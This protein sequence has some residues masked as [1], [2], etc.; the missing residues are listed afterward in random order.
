METTQTARPNLVV[1]TAQQL[2]TAASLR[3]IGELIYQVRVPMAFGGMIFTQLPDLPTRITGHYLGATIEGALQ[4][5]DELLFPVR[6]PQAAPPIPLAYEI[7]LEDFR[8]HQAHIEAELWH[9]LGDSGMPHALLR[10]A[11]INFSR[12]II[13]A[14]TLG[15]IKY[16]GVDLNWIKGLLTNHYQMPESLV[17]RY[18]AAYRE[19]AERHLHADE[20]LLTNWLNH[21]LALEGE[22]GVEEFGIGGQL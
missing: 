1:L 13:A 22:Q 2:Y 16:L 17:T 7:A 6:L 4:R 18:L 15:N 11:N 9:M 20:P 21:I 12:D 5:V 10:R 8:I 3:E 19:A 14:L